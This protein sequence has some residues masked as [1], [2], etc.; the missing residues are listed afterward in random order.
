MNLRKKDPPQIFAE[1][2]RLKGV[3]DAAALEMAILIQGLWIA[4]PDIFTPSDADR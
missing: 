3:A 4:Y 2:N 1:I